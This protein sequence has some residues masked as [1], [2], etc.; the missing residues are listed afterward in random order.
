MVKLVIGIVIAA[1][2]ALVAGFVPIMEVP[3]TETVQYQDTETYYEDE[4]YEDIETYY[5]DEPYEVTETYTEAAP[6]SYEA[7]SYVKEGIIKERY[8]TIIPGLP[9]MSGEKE[10]SIHEA[11]VDVKNTDDIAGSFTIHF[12]GITPLWGMT[13]LLTKKLDISPGEV[14]TAVCPAEYIGTWSYNVT[15]STK[16][17]EK[18]RTVTKYR[19]VE[20]ERPITKYRQVEEERTVT[21]ERLETHY[22]KVPIF[23][24]LRSRFQG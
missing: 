13:Q 24:Y 17:I 6:L 1:I 10:V 22:K 2:I 12:S 4:P 8:E 14:K 21:K 3:Y 19:Q 7:T 9:P 15:P 18:E 5:V 11:W 16:T 23:E 20:K